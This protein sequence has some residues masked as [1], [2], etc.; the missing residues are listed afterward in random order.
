MHDMDDRM[1][2]RTDYA[3]DRYADRQV[4]SY[5]NHYGLL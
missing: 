5:G 4:G 1:T 3:M 2:A